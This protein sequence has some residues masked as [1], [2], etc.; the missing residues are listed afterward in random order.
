MLHGE[1]TDAN[2]L[3]GN[4]NHAFALDLADF[5][6]NDAS[7]IRVRFNRRTAELSNSGK[8][9]LEFKALRDPR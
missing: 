5:R 3:M 4:G 6:L 2:C 1:F 9:L 8:S 7:R